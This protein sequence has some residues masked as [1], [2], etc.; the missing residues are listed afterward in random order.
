MHDLITFGRETVQYPDQYNL[1]WWT[2]TNGDRERTAMF[3]DIYD[4]FDQYVFYDDDLDN[5][6]PADA[7]SIRDMD[8]LKTMRLQCYSVKTLMD[9]LR[10]IR[11]EYGYT[12]RDVNGLDDVYRRLEEE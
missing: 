5:E 7:I 12:A 9:K 6:R 8:V 2:F 3:I 10:Q 11:T 4:D 1:Q